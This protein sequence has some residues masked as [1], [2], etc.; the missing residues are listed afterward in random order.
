VQAL[1]AGHGGEVRFESDPATGTVVTVTL[2]AATPATPM[3]ILDRPVL[4]A[5]S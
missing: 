4:P 2:P 1:I 3:E 5:R